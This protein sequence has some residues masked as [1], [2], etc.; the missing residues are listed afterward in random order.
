MQCSTK[1][2]KMASY[3]LWDLELLCDSLHLN[4]HK[5]E[6]DEE[7]PKDVCWEQSWIGHNGVEVK[8]KA[9]KTE[10]TVI[11]CTVHCYVIPNSFIQNWMKYT[12]LFFSSI[13][14]R[15][16]LRTVSLKRVRLLGSACNMI[17]LSKRQSSVNIQVLW[18]RWS[19]DSSVVSRVLHVFSPKS[20]V[21]G[22]I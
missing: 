3:D 9:P 21:N 22:F 19:L 2:E 17:V 4:G 10:E 20:I 7:Y 5:N 1:R 15:Q 14:W 16:L 11:A 6:D 13:N 18:F 8:M 12:T